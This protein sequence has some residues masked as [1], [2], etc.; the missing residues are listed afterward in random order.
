MRTE[1]VLSNMRSV[2]TSKAMLLV[3]AV[4]CLTALSFTDV[5][6]T[7]FSKDGGN[8]DVGDAEEFDAVWDKVSGLMS[9]TVGKMVSAGIF[10]AAII[11]KDKLGLP[12]TIASCLA[13]V[14]LPGVPSLVDGFSFTI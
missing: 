8:L 6:A 2:V 4:T 1:K 7:N 9:G 3:L 12:M 5:F 10:V 14:A 13:G 11:N